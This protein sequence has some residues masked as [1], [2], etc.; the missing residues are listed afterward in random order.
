MNGIQK[1]LDGKAE[2]VRINLWSKL[3]KQIGE[4]YGVASPNTSLLING[5]GDIVYQ[6]K[7]MPDRKQIIAEANKTS[8]ERG[9]L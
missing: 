9:E 7:G 8:S 1:E 4:K 2:V 6:H 5:H 3:G